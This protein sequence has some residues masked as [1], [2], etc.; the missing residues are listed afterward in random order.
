MA[1]IAVERL[2]EANVFQSSARKM[3]AANA[4]RNA[5]SL[6]NTGIRLD[7]EIG[8]VTTEGLTQKF[9]VAAGNAQLEC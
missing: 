1:T 5:A 7:T 8:V 9:S 6:L 3:T 2:P 4:V